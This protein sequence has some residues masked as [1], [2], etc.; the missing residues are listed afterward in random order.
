MGCIGIHCRSDSVIPQYEK[1]GSEKDRQTIPY[2][3][4]EVNKRI[5]ENGS[6]TIE[7]N[8]RETIEQNASKQN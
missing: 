2:D 4:D 7:P 6:K 1:N 3:K 5:E 8:A